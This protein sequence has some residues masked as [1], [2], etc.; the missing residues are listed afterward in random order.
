MNMDH[1]PKRRD[2][3]RGKGGRLQREGQNSKDNAAKIGKTSK[4]ALKTKD[5][6]GANFEK[7]KLSTVKRLN[8]T[9]GRTGTPRE[10]EQARKNPRSRKKKAF[11]GGDL[12]NEITAPFMRN[13]GRGVHRE[14]K[15]P[16]RNG[17]FF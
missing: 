16:P 3:G 7:N 6:Q 4:R 9:K 2:W 10:G 13:L 1:H 12:A 17:G 11:G 15:G 8:A 5:R 14:K